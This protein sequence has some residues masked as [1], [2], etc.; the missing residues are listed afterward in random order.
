MLIRAMLI[1]VVLHLVVLISP[2]GLDG[3]GLTATAGHGANALNMVIAQRRGGDALDPGIRKSAMIKAQAAVRKPASPAESNAAHFN[4]S[5]F[6]RSTAESAAS[7]KVTS[8]RSTE[9]TP[10]DDLV[11]SA[12]EIGQYR[13]NVAR[14]A[15]QFKVYP[16]LAREKGWEGVVHV[17]VAM[18]IGA[19]V[20]T[21]LLANSSGY[22]VL[23]R[24]A[25]HMVEQAVNLAILPEGM[26]GRRLAISLPVEYRLA[27]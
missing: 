14:S 13:L 17:S 24:Q 5:P 10:A 18:P 26:R 20:P 23:D 9:M 6:F 15:R 3:L 7:G 11:A 25:L 2:V 4:F 27:D 12:A 21:V 16:P 1:S 19:G 8:N 22:E